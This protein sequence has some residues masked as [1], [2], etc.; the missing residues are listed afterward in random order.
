MNNIA[1][2]REARA[3]NHLP[4][5]VMASGTLIAIAIVVAALT[6]GGSGMMPN[7]QGGI[8]VER[9]DTLY[10]CQARPKAPAPCVNLSDGSTLAFGDISR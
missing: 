4:Y 9:N 3:D 7:P 10:L 8:W 6:G 2:V 1:G 5:A